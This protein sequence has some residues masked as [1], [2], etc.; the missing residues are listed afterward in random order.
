MLNESKTEAT[1]SVCPTV[2]L[3]QLLIHICYVKPTY[4]GL[5]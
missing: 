2:K 5:T 4:V 1:V 3:L